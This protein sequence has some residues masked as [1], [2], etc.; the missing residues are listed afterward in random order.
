MSTVALLFFSYVY[1]VSVFITGILL[2]VYDGATTCHSMQMMHVYTIISMVNVALGVSGHFFSKT[3]E[4]DLS[5][6][7]GSGN[8]CSGFVTAVGLTNLVIG[9]TIIASPGDCSETLWLLYVRV[10]WL[11][12]ICAIG[13]F[14]V[15]AIGF[16][17]YYFFEDNPVTG[18]NVQLPSHQLPQNYNA[19]GVTVVI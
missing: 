7:R 5:A 9:A 19:H 1:T 16:F 10:T 2:F 12:Q 15:A 11:T 3:L 8:I 13:A 6:N 4:Q 18:V 17:L 14:V